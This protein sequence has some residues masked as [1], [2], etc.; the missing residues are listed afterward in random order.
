MNDAGSRLHQ[1][2]VVLALWCLVVTGL[3]ASCSAAPAASQ[4]PTVAAT[5]TAPPN[6]TVAA[7]PAATVQ[8]TVASRTRPARIDGL[9]V[10]FVDELPREAQQTLALIRHGGPFPYR[11]D[12]TI[13][14]NRERRLPIKPRGYYREYTVRTPGERDRGARRIVMGAGGEIYYTAD[15]YESFVRVIER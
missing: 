1:L 10:V 3:I 12:G 9:P 11:Q 8:P 15:H 4:A 13:F 14:Q 7:T 2:V 5:P 6:Q